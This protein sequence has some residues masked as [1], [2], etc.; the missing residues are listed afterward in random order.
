M[1]S[2][3]GWW[4]LLGF[5]FG[6]MMRKPENK[7]DALKQLFIMGPFAWVVFIPVSIWVLCGGGPMGVRWRN[8]DE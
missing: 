1:S 6:P 8:D 3:L 4:C 5:I 2:L 7:L